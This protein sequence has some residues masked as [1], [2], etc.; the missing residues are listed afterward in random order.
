MAPASSA[1]EQRVDD[2]ARVVDEEPIG[3][4]GDVVERAP[5]GP[6]GLEHRGQGGP[7]PVGER[8]QVVGMTPGAA[9][10]AAAGQGGLRDHGREDERAF[11]GDEGERLDRLVG[12]VEGV[13][14]VDEDVVGHRGEQHLLDLGEGH[15]LR[16]RGAEHPLGRVRGSGP[17]LAPVPLG[18]P[19]R[20]Q[21]VGGE[22]RDVETGRVPA[23]VVRHGAER[24][25]EGGRPVGGREVVEHVRHRDERGEPGAPA[26]G[27][28]ADPERES[29]A[30]QLGGV[31][32]GVEQPEHRLGDHERQAVLEA[33]AE[34]VLEMADLVEAGAG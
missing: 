8:G 29:G 16:E 27:A 19:R 20:G 9:L 17:D 23:G 6:S 7:G 32:T 25:D 24:V 15:P 31:D 2:Q 5:A 3:E 18:E 33:L 30:D 13:A 14:A 11:L 22:R 4:P 10:L 34:P 1:V 28:V 12:E 21:R 26:R